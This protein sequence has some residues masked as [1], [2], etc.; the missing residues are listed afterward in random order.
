MNYLRRLPKFTYLAPTTVAEVCALLA[1]HQDRAAVMAGGTNLLPKMKRREKVPEYLISL[2]KVPGLNHVGYSDADGLRLGPMVTIHDIDTSPIVR[3]KFPALAQAAENLASAQVRNSATVGG[4][5]GNAA[6]CADTPPSLLALDA[7][8]KL[9]SASG[10]RTLTVDQ[11]YVAPFQSAMR[12]DEM[13]VEIEVP[14][15]AEG[16]TGVYMRHAFRGA[17][18]Y[19]LV[20]IAVVLTVHDRVCIDIKI[21]GS[22]C[23]HCW[24][25]EGCKNPCPTPFRATRAEETLRGKVLDEALIQEAALLAAR[26][27]RPIVDRL[28]TKEMITV[29]TRRALTRAWKEGKQN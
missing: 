20:G 11:F 13:L 21:T 17:M 2:A 4:N 7:K 26:D 29:Y 15:T 1:E 12:T 6:P 19:P 16:T 27:A 8:L 5:L 18:D 28:Y 23:S 25:R 3:Q 10:Q 22:F 9:I 24:C 14:N